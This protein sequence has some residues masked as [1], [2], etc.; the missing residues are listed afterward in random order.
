MFAVNEYVAPSAY[1]ILEPLLAVFQPVN[2]SPEDQVR[3][4]SVSA[5]ATP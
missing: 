5:S 1:D 3:V 4:L 2:D